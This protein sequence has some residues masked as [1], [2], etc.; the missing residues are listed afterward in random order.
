MQPF[1]HN[2]HGPKTEGCPF[3]GRGD[4]S[5]S[6]TMSTGSRPTSIPSGILIHVA[7]GGGA[8]PLLVDGRAGSPSNRVSLGS[9]PTGTS[10]RSGILIHSAIWP[11]QIWA[12]NWGLCPFGEGTSVPNPHVTQCG[13]D[14]GHNGHGPKIGKGAQ[15]PFPGGGAGL[16]CNT[17]LLGRGLPAYEVSS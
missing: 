8:L 10:I 15:P 1:G 16:P 3:W 14:R 17:N 9:S 11:Q 13:Q 2:R 7:V 12:E 4:G 5:P 6:N